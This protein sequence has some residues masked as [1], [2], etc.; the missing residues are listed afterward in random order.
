[1]VSEMH[2]LRAIIIFLKTQRLSDN[3]HFI[4]QQVMQIQKPNSW[5]LEY[6]NV[7][8]CIKTITTITSTVYMDT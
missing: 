5:T 8:D 2:K 7:F 6:L 1:M 4:V 3:K